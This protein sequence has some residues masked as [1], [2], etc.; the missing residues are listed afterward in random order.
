MDNLKCNLQCCGALQCFQMVPAAMNL[1]NNSVSAPIKSDHWSLLSG[2]QAEGPQQMVVRRERERWQGWWIYTP[3]WFHRPTNK[4]LPKN[5]F[6]LARLQLL[7]LPPFICSF[8]RSLRLPLFSKCTL[9]FS[10]AFLQA[11][12]FLSLRNNKR[13]YSFFILSFR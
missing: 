10:A 11:I 7:S 9:S 2:W 13:T 5:T 3:G 6:H 8:L 12:L 1:Q 4:H